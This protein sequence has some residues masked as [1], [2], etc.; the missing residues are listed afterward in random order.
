MRPFPDIAI[1]A[2]ARARDQCTKR[3]RALILPGIEEIAPDRR[4][5]CG[6]FPFGFR[7][8]ARAGPAGKCIGLIATDMHHR[9]GGIDR[10]RSAQ[11]VAPPLAVLLPPIQR[12]IPAFALR[13]GPAIHKPQRLIG[14]TARLHEGDPVA[15]ADRAVGKLIGREIRLMARHFAVIGKACLRG[16]AVKPHLNQATGMGGVG[17][18]M[19]FPL[20]RGAIGGLIDRQ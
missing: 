4:V 3:L 6:A 10:H 18:G 5:A 17:D 12:R 15:V 7:W 19:V 20:C 9:R 8:K 1:H 11:G 2:T 16:G 13:A 14:V